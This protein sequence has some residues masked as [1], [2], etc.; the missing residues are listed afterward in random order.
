MTVLKKKG[1]LVQNKLVR[2]LKSKKSDSRKVQSQ[3]WRQS[4]VGSTL[5]IFYQTYDR[6]AIILGIIIVII[7]IITTIM[8]II[9]IKAKPQL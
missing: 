8:I 5:I 2:Q 6:F 1:S 7:T 3:T 4:L 9:T